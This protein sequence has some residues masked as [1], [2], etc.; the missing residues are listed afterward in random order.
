MS[1]LDNYF[2]ELEARKVPRNMITQL[3]WNF[4]EMKKMPTAR[5]AVG[6]GLYPWYHT[7]PKRVQ[8]YWNDILKQWDEG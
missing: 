4:I 8:R 2:K 3:D 7:Q 5:L 1:K 6:R